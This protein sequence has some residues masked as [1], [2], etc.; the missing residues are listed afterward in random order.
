[1]RSLRISE[2]VKHPCFGDNVKNKASKIHIAR[3]PGRLSFSKHCDYV[4]NDLLY[5]GADYDTYAAVSVEPRNPDEQKNNSISRLEVYNLNSDFPELRISFTQENFTHLVSEKLSSWTFY[6]LKI[7]DL[8]M[9]SAN[10]NFQ[11][12]S[13]IKVVIS[14]NLPIAAGMSSSHAL[15]LSSLNA[16]L[17]ALDAAQLLKHINTLEPKW[18]LETASE[19][20]PLGNE[21]LEKNQ[22]LM[23][24]LK[25]CQKIEIAK[26]FNSG[27]GDQ[28]AQIL[29]RKGYF[30]FIKLFPEI[31]FTYKK[32]ENDISFMILP[33]FI[34]AEKTSEE[35][36]KQKKFFAKY[37][38][39]NKLYS[40]FTNNK[41]IKENAE[42]IVPQEYH[43]M[44]YLGDLLYILS[45][46]EILMKLNDLAQGQCHDGRLA[47]RTSSRIGISL[48]AHDETIMPL[49]LYA[50]AEGARL[51][52]LKKSFSLEK[53]CK[54]I[55]L[56]HE[57]E[58]V[59]QSPQEYLDM[60]K[61]L[62]DYHGRYASSTEFNDELQENALKITGVYACSIMGAGLGGNNLAIVSRDLAQN[63]KTTLIQEFYSFYKLEKQAQNHILINQSADGLSYLGEF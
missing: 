7:L 27:L 6:I 54:H 17:K 2:L 8:L 28:A 39:L 50:L 5:I 18:L 11:E 43:P 49:S 22:D 15:I 46:K 53:L 37:H 41:L 60:E 38:E 4:N 16:L 21:N 14:S 58:K 47:K 25:F 20:F 23:S 63:I 45:D 56:S 61:P 10:I 52:D 40:F 30:C 3:C 9:L 26:G 59:K 55:N 51:R 31:H 19:E 57:A 12:I 33:S 62:G 24:L 32:I 29:S 1:M 13:S 35:Y 34:K 44:K 36:K 42:T 48:H